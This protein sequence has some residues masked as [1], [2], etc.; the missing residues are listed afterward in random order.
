MAVG[1]CFVASVS[2]APTVGERNQERPS[3]AV[4]LQIQIRQRGMLNFDANFNY[5]CSA[6]QH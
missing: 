6:E 3:L 4:G 2:E 5:A 1:I